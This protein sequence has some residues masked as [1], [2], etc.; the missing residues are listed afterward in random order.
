MTA[1]MNDG[2][3][4][5]FHEEIDRQE[6]DEWNHARI[7]RVVALRAEKQRELNDE[8]RREAQAANVGRRARLDWNAS[9]QI[10]GPAREARCWREAENDRERY[11]ADS[12]C[13]GRVGERWL[14]LTARA[15]PA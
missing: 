1:G 11:S 2:E 9:R 5:D 8:G 6:S 7:A 10:R 3:G 15:G 12:R 13:F 4:S 14:A